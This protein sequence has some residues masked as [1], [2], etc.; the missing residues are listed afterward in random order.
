[1][2]QEN[3]EFQRQQNISNVWKL[4]YCIYHNVKIN[5]IIRTFL[6]LLSPDSVIWRA[7][8]EIFTYQL[9]TK[10]RCYGQ[11]DAKV[12][13]NLHRHRCFQ[14]RKLHFVDI[15][16]PTKCNIFSTSTSNVDAWATYLSCDVE[17]RAD[18]LT[19]IPW[20]LHG[21]WD[22]LVRG[23]IKRKCIIGPV[24]PFRKVSIKF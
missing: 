14:P 19:I 3:I 6:L 13:R 16:I 5:H 7:K 4:V 20:R 8:W 1:M 10:I 22:V 21:V 23:Q 12:V 11:N 24:S 17:L 18:F 15:N 2:L 9:S